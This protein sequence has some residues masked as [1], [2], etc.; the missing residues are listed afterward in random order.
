MRTVSHHDEIARYESFLSYL[1]DWRESLT[2]IA[3]EELILH[4]GSPDAVGLACVDLVKGFTTEGNLASPRI[5]SIIQR[6]V[7]LFQRAYDAGVHEFVL[8]QDAHPED[9]IQFES[10]GPHCV[11]GSDESETVDE[12]ASLSFAA[13]FDVIPKRSTNSFVGTTFERWI[14]SRPELRYLVVVGDCTDICVYQLAAHLRAKSI[15]ESRR[16]NIVVP[17]DCVQTY[18]LPVDV[19]REKRLMAHD[20]DF[21]HL[22]FLYHMAL[23]GIQVV[24]SVT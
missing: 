22:V 6:I 4:S 21:F 20:G 3:L 12:L 5:A 7:Y 13:E 9:S 14:D 16:L 15:V 19:A 18:D 10:Y 2:K 24:S 11:M 17:E 23:N 1:I 8:I